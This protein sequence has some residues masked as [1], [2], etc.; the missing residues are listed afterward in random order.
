M[1][2]SPAFRVGFFQSALKDSASK[3][4]CP[5]LGKGDECVSTR[6][7]SLTDLQNDSEKTIDYRES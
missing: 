7:L 5:S 4:S 3:S 6:Y 1:P 2:K